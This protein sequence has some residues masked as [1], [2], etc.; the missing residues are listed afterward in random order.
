MKSIQQLAISSLLLLTI[1][2]HAGDVEIPDQLPELSSPETGQLGTREANIGLAPG[3][4]V[5]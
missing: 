5:P 4:Q 2:A 1:Y 3:E